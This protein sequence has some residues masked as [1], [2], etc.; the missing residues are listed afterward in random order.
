MDWQNGLKSDG[1]NLKDEEINLIDQIW[2][3]EN[4]RPMFEVILFDIICNE[5]LKLLLRY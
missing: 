1:I 3:E 4:G 2:T 5:S